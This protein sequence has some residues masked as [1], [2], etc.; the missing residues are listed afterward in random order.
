M[1]EPITGGCLCG[2]IRYRLDAK[3]SVTAICHCTH[4]A[5]QGGSLFSMICG[6]PDGQF[7]VTKGEMTVYVDTADSGNKVERKFCN[8]CGSPI[9]SDV[10]AMPGMVFV[11]AGTL[12]DWRQFKPTVE[13]YRSRTAEWFPAFDGVH[14]MQ[15]GS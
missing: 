9:I 5:R 10:K 15:E 2:A 7:H 14:S 12:D 13:V 1:S 4:C 11:K 3:P 8:Q 6:V